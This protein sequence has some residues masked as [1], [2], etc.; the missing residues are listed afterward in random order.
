MTNPR[1]KRTIG[2]TTNVRNPQAKSSVIAFIVVVEVEE[3]GH[4]LPQA[5]EETE[6]DP[7]HQH[8]QRD[9]HSKHVGRINWNVAWLQ[10]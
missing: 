6:W 1:M 5:R 7:N 8:E 4:N 10:T 2:A 9:L 3:D